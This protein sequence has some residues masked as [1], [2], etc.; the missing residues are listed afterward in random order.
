MLR[1]LLTRPTLPSLPSTSALASTLFDNSLPGLIQI[2]T[3]TKR[4]GGS[5][6]NGRNSVGKRLGIKKYGGQQVLAGN[7]I[8]RQRG[9]TW[10]AGQHVEKGR[11]H[12]L[13]ATVP[14][15]VQFY[16]DTVNG[17]ERKLVGITATAEERLPR[18]VEKLGRDRYFG[19][20]DVTR[21]RDVW[22]G[23]EVSPFEVMSEEDLK[24]L[25]AEAQATTDSTLSGE[26]ARA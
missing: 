8:V 6:K 11:D 15:F 1:S 5:S 9:T 22:E 17:K 26:A 23:E 16:R 24:R 25:I 19:K 3:A 21:E 10:H 20:V 2:R 14:G 7:I 4:G 12:T 13:F 18:D